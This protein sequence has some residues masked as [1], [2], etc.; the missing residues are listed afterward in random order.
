M[1]KSKLNKIPKKSQKTQKSRKNAVF[2]VPRVTPCFGPFFR[3][4]GI[5]AL[6]K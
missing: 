6:S 2:G 3:T 1:I 5:F 4:K